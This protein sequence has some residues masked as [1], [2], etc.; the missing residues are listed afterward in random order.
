MF[1]RNEDEQLIFL[2]TSRGTGHS[3]QRPQLRQIANRRS[4]Q[5]KAG[6]PEKWVQPE[7]QIGAR[8]GARIGVA[9]VTSPDAHSIPTSKILSQLPAFGLIPQ[10]RWELDE[11]DDN[12]LQCHKSGILPIFPVAGSV[13]RAEQ[14]ALLAVNERFR[15]Y[16]SPRFGRYLDTSK[17]GP[18]LSAASLED[19]LER[20][21]PDFGITPVAGAMV[22]SSCHKPERLGSLNW[23]MD[24]TLIESYVTGG[25]MP[26][27]HELKASER[28]ELY[29]KL[30]QEYFAIDKDKPGILKSWLLRQ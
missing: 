28:R 16:G 8:A 14:D 3:R 15:G 7:F 5:S 9:A 23:P 11:G 4:R 10:G 19:R 26:L 29:A 24:K 6:L 12:C 25:Q 18:G 22:C 21:G 27:G 30:I 2:I 1:R 13:K 20:F 17:L